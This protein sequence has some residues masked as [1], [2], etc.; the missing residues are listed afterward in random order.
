MS[1]YCQL[2]YEYV[3]YPSPSSP[4]GT[5]ADNGC[6]V[7]CAGMIVEAMTGHP[8]P[9]HVAGRMA[10]ECG[11]REGFGTSLVIFGPVFAEKFGLRCIYH[12]RIVYHRAFVKSRRVV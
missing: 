1:F 9:P 10:K 4:K 6:G 5:I 3:P 2:D 11:A 8:F 7:C 12:N